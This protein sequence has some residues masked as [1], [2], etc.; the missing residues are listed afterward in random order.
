MRLLPEG[1]TEG[2]ALLLRTRGAR[3]FVDGAVAVVLPGYLIAIG[4]SSAE[5]GA[6]V[7]ATLL[8]SA[9]LTLALGFGAHLFTRTRLLRLAAVT[10]VL[11]GLGFAFV[12]TFW[13]LL[14]I[15]VIG[16]L[17]PS[18][19]DVSI[20]LPTE[21]ALLP[22]TVP[23]SQRTALYARYNLVAYVL[24]AVGSLVAGVPDAVGDR[25]DLDPRWA[26]GSV[27]LVYAAIGVVLLLW[28]HD[29]PDDLAEGDSGRATRLD[30]SRR[31]VYRLAATFTLDAFGGGFVVQ[32]MLVLW[33]HVRFDLSVAVSGAVF[34]W[35]GLL[36][37]GSALVAARIAGRIGLI[38]TMA[39]TH[40]PANGLLMATALMPNAP[41]AVACLLARAAL[42]Q[43]DV[44]ARQSYV[45]AVVTPG[46]RAAAA[47]VTNVPRSL[48]SAL[49]PLATGWML[50][51]STF[52][53]PLL[54]GGALKAAYDLLL[55]WQ[56]RDVRPPEELVRP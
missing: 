47:S 53:W 6:V 43:M 54:I 48:A 15:A 14:P 25:F 51:H 22:A 17:N 12:T 26:L 50:E 2:A 4:L 36:A 28:Y 45:M 23:D 35:A 7:T 10:M 24:A 41:L 9:A 39:F 21:Q 37:G 3:A 31:I 20:F 49:P 32:S 38:R 27:F 55:L 44:P 16:T 40:L 30:E 34:F 46:E 8:G 29:L 18:S 33:L 11:T 5:V 56:F 42:S 52:G 1:A 13:A 19:G